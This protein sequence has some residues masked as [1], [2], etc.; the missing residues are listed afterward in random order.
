MIFEW[1]NYQLEDAGLVDSWMDAKAVAMTGIDQ[2]WDAYWNAVIADAKNY[3]G[4]RDFCKI[5]RKN[6]MAVAAV[7]YG[8]YRGIATVSEIIVD[9]TRRGKGLGTQILR[10]LVAHSDELLSGQAHEFCA[11]IFPDNLPSQKAFTK[12]GFVL[13]HVHEDGT[14]LYYK[15]ERACV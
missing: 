1:I 14:V 12:A 11:V 15:M 8:S 13:D 5:V 10:D 2:G 6:G 3:P 4:C 7:V 9:P